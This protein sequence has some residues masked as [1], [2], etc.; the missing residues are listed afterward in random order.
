MYA[1]AEWKGDTWRY[2]KAGWR[3]PTTVAKYRKDDIIRPIE[4]IVVLRQNSSAEQQG[5][6]IADM[7]CACSM[8]ATVPLTDVWNVGPSDSP[9]TS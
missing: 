5:D 8:G 4:V 3:R 1:T 9:Y 6:A 7:C 2:D